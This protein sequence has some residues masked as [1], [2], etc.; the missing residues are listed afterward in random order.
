M[1]IVRSKSSV[2]N[3]CKNGINACLNDAPPE[4]GEWT[5]LRGRIV[6]ES[7]LKQVRASF[8]PGNQKHH[9]MAPEPGHDF[10]LVVS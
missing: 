8:P 5:L 9:A 4:K 6:R 7:S 10:T 2:I 1:Q 3:E